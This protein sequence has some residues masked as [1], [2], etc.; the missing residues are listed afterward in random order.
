MEDYL[1]IRQFRH[2]FDEIEQE[3]FEVSAVDYE[4]PEELI[5]FFEGNDGKVL[6]FLSWEVELLEDISFLR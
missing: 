3:V 6:K 2:V 5:W 1:L 4:Q